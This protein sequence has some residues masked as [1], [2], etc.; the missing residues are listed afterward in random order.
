LI[1]NRGCGIGDLLVHLWCA[2]SARVGG[3]AVVRINPRDH[4]GLALAFGMRPEDLTRER[5]PE[6]SRVAVGGPPGSGLEER[7]AHGRRQMSRFDAWCE[8]FGL[9]RLAPCRPPYRESPELG[10]WAES[11]WRDMENRG[12][13]GPRVLIFPQTCGGPIRD[14][15]WPSWVSL[16]HQLDAAGYTV[17]ADLP[18]QEPRNRDFPRVFQGRPLLSMVALLVRADL[19]V[20]ADSGPA[21]LGATK[22]IATLALCGPTRPEIVFGH[23]ADVVSGVS[24]ERHDISCVGCHFRADRGFE[25]RCGEGCRALVRLH[26]D[27][28]FEHAVQR[29]SKISPLHP[30]PDEPHLSLERS[31]H[32]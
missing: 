10:A 9:P 20:A 30:P 29:L 12:P 13:G 26:P 18:R 11:A 4:A 8:Y 5:S 2:Y 32:V 14:W 27:R 23:A 28:V 6:G 16:A 3:A 22:G 7:L 24:A 17:V 19:V 31:F 21:H 1:D 25:G 15:P